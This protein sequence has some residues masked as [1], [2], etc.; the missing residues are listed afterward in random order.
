MKYLYLLLTLILFVLSLKGIA[1]VDNLTSEQL[2]V[3]QKEGVVIIDIRTPEEWKQQGT[4]PNTSKIM[5]FDQNRK[6]LTNDFMSEFQKVVTSKD[7]AFV[8]VCRSGN[9]TGRVAKYL[10][11]NLG[12]T[13]VAHLEKGMNQWQAEKHPVER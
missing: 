8:L 1:A 2:L 11:D 5:F 12:Y 10:H 4:I 13:N 3:A 9:R 6:P 7:Q